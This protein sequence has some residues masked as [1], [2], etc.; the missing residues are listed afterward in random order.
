MTMTMTTPVTEFDASLEAIIEINTAEIQ[1][2]LVA[3]QDEL[4][5]IGPTFGMNARRSQLK[6]DKN[7]LLDQ[8]LGLRSVLC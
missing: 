3:I 2:R 7:E 6:R 5:E 8:L 4:D 1:K